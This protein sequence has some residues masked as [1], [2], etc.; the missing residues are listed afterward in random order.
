MSD[1]TSNDLLGLIKKQ[2]KEIENL[3]KQHAALSARVAM[4]ENPRET[5]PSLY[6]K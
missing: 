3:K 1:L 4:L 5:S 6:P 2:E